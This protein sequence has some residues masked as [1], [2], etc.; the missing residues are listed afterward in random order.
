VLLVLVGVAV[1][2]S[3]QSGTRDRYFVRDPF[4]KWQSEGPVAA[5]NWQVKVQPAKLS[6]HQRLSVRL[7]VTVDRG[8]I[9]AR[10]THG[11]LAI[12]VEILDAQ[13]RKWRIHETFDPTKI[14]ADAKARS[15]EY[16]QEAFVVPGDYTVSVAVVDSR[17]SEH[18]FTRLAL[19]VP[20]IRKDPLPGASAD[21][22]AV[23]FIRLLNEPDGWFQPY[24]R[25]RLK[26]PVATKAPVHVDLFVN[27]TPSQRAQGSV[28]GFRRNMSVLLPALKILA[29]VR[30]E[31]G[32]LEVSLV[33]LVR[34][35]TWEQKSARGLDWSRMREPFAEGN[36]GTIDAQLLASKREM[37]QFFWDELRGRA[38]PHTE[39]AG[40]ARAGKRVLIVLSAPVFLDGQN[41]VEPATVAKDPDRRVFYIRYRALPPRALQI[42]PDGTPIPQAA[43]MP[44]DELEHVVKLLD[45]KVFAVSTPEEFRKALAAILGEIGRM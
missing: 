24:L 30:L 18:S 20:P 21:L 8:E 43:A 26:L 44:V 42:A 11:E 14:P 1:A 13:G 19:K 40:D 25:G 33:D 27:L 9:E 41:K 7:A 2:A 39:D 37:L 12:L 3:A 45:A 17:T 23:E 29:G 31:S 35:K 5:L 4:E 22:P 16:V 6:V 34:R 36:P 38:V 10:R 15:V 28:R 32:R